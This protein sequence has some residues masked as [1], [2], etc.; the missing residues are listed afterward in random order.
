[1][2]SALDNTGLSPVLKKN[3]KDK[4]KKRNF[5]A[6]AKEGG[7]SPHKISMGKCKASA[8]DTIDTQKC[9]VPATDTESRSTGVLCVY[10]QD[11]R[12]QRRALV[13]AQTQAGKTNQLLTSYV[14]RHETRQHNQVTA[15]LYQT[16]KPGTL[17]HG[18]TKNP[19]TRHVKM[20]KISGKMPGNMTS[21]TSG[22]GH[23]GASG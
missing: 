4:S 2:N 5:T 23:L 11:T 17:P 16:K 14:L 22:P 18:Y 19:E 9:S 15:P 21:K 1:M 10:N 20:W 7:S 3:T 12:Q 13:G 6:E 8:M